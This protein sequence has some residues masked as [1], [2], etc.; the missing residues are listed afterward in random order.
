M[1]TSA[2]SHA[3]VPAEDMILVEG[4]TSYLTG[5]LQSVFGRL[6]LTPTKLEFRQFPIWVLFF[7]A[8]GIIL[9][10]KNII[11]P[12]NVLFSIR[13]DAIVNLTRGKWGLNTKIIEVESR[14]GMKL[15]LAVDD[16]AKWRAAWPE[17]P[18]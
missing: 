6:Y 1:S 2:V 5:K 9:A 12:K 10:R 13:R 14:D 7:G 15:R 8:L 16:W 11:K 3:L 4:V 17:L 18:A